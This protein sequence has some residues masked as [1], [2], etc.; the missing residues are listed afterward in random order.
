MIGDLH[1][2]GA[3][4]SLS[5]REPEGEM[6]KFWYQAEKELLR[7]RRRS[8]RIDFPIAPLS[9]FWYAIERAVAFLTPGA[10]F[11][12]PIAARRRAEE[13]P[14]GLTARGQKARAPRRGYRAT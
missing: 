5:L 14:P 4:V 8:A 12:M 7:R 11:S 13:L 10:A 6:E 9:F 3:A 1:T 2:R